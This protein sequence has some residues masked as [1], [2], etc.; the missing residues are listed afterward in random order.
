MDQSKELGVLQYL[1]A[2]ICN[3]LYILNK[4]LLLE[5][6][7]EKQ[8]GFQSAKMSDNSVFYLS[9]VLMQNISYKKL[10]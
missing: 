4:R 1:I 7:M 9:S 8:N 10:D 3:L 2:L 5:L 6:T